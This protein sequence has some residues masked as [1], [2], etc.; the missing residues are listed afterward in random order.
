MLTLFRGG[1]A[2]LAF[3]LLV[4]GIIIEIAIAGSF[5]TYFLSHAGLGERLSARAFAAAHAGVRDAQIKI[6][7]NKELGPVSYSL[8]V[9]ADSTK[10]VVT[11]DATNSDYYIY[12]ITSTG[13]ASTRLRKLVATLVVNK[14]TGLAQLK[15][16]VEAS[17]Q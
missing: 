12:T 4:G 5:I 11:W 15:S 9:G 17:I 2:T 14:T 6:T 13:S 7:R 1:Q 3:V 16:L 10:V 8:P